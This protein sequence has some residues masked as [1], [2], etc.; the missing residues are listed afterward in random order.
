MRSKRLIPKA[1][2]THNLQ[3]DNKS[4]VSKDNC[5]ISTIF[6]LNTPLKQC[7]RSSKTW[8]ASLAMMLL[9]MMTKG[10]KYCSRNIIENH[11]QTNK[12]Q[13]YIRQ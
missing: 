6:A 12:K 11:N 10:Q 9:N 13:T 2:T 8:Y 4:Y 1:R 3:K 5:I 7:K